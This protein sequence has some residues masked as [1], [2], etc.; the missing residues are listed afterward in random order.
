MSKKPSI[1]IIDDSSMTT[2]IYRYLV[3]QFLLDP[4][5]STYN[6]PWDVNVLKFSSCDL[7]I[8]D[9]IMDDV[10]GTEFIEEVLH[11]LYQ[12]RYHEFPN[13][14]FASS[15]DAGDLHERIKLKK[16]DTMIP[17]YRV[18]QKPL[19]PESLKETIKA[20]CPSIG[21]CIVENS[22]VPNSELPWLVSIKKAW[23][24]IFGIKEDQTTTSHSLI[25]L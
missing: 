4:N 10:T 16:I 5:V 14:I 6:H 24:E 17:S 11:E 23:N 13:V 22:V 7:I 8:I 21:E 18:L 25:S 19:S 9:E 3:N 2:K 1:C 20:I 12:G 15:L